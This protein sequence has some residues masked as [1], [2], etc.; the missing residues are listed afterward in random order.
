M[1]SQTIVIE[2]LEQLY[3]E[4]VNI[5]FGDA[6][7]KEY[8]ISS[9][10]NIQLVL[11]G[12]HWGG[13]VDYRIA[14]FVLKL[15]N[16]IFKAYSVATEKRVTLRSSQEI[17][18]SLVINV[19]VREGSSWLNIDWDKAIQ[20]VVNKMDS[21]HLFWLGVV[22]ITVFASY[23]SLGKVLEYN[24]DIAQ[25]AKDEKQIIAMQNIT[26]EALYGLRASQSSMDYLI[27]NMQ[28]GDK[29]EIP[30]KNRVLTKDQAEALL[31]PP[32]D[33]S[34]IEKSLWVDDTFEVMILNLEKQTIKLKRGDIQFEATSMPMRDQDRQKLFGVVKKSIDEKK[35][36][37]MGLQLTIKFKDNKIDMCSITGI[38]E[39]REGADTLSEA[40]KKVG[41]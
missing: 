28:E 22:G 2:S 27:R 18:D 23:L 32:V 21:K 30:S 11:K 7:I 8:K 5:V 37:S 20:G 29:L 34:P 17:I 38:G 1:E 4:A 26:K 13:Y 24:K 12:S 31:P 25:Y 35:V 33:K 15:Q 41:R 3:G 14:K 16:E 9:N 40:F 6:P 19:E 10:V 36:Q 39:K